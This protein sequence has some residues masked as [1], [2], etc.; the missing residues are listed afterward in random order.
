VRTVDEGIE[1]LTGIPA[2]QLDSSGKFP[3]GSV[4]RRVEM[5]LIELAKKRLA[6]AQETKVENV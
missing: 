1:I 4:N 2:G 3:E 6:V 5:Q